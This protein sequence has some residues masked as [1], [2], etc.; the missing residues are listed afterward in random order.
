MSDDIGDLARPT[1]P[2]PNCRVMLVCGPPASGKSTYVKNHAAASD[3]VIDLDMIAR[4]LG[5][6]RDRPASALAT[7]LTIRN[8]R[9]A[10]LSQEPPHRVAWVILGAPSRALR[11]WWRRTLGVKPDDQILLGPSQAELRRRILNDP[12]RKLVVEHHLKLVEQWIAR[13]KANDPGIAKRGVDDDGLP[14]DPLHAWNRKPDP[15]RP[16]WYGTQRWRKRA[17]HQLRE[18][19]LCAMCLRSGQVT[20]AR[21]ADHVTPHYGNQ[22]AFWFGELQSL[23]ITHHDLTKRRVEVWGYACDV[24]GDGWPTDPKHP[25]NA[26]G[27]PARNKARGGMV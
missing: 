19:P 20:P 22:K 7:L 9:L 5:Y 27:H 3:I 23:C 17:R 18:H 26:A 6:H 14:T 4:E 12:D 8:A 11:Q 25:A 1:L 16:R 2:P 13:E 10:A 24:D 21:V 15:K